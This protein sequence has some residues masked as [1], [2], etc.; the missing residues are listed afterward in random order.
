MAPSASRF[1]L[2]SCCWRKERFS[3]PCQTVRQKVAWSSSREKVVDMEAKDESV[4]PESGGGPG[5]DP[6]FNCGNS[7]PDMLM[8]VRKS[9]DKML[10]NGFRDGMVE[11]NCH[12]QG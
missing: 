9:M 1:K 5:I 6:G 3:M 10:L 4:S 12:G 11:S 8:R 2:A 7:Q